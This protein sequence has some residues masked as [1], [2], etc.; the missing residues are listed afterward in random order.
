M[1]AGIVSANVALA[2]RRHLRALHPDRRRGEPRQLGRPAVQPE[3]RGDRHQLADLLAAPA[4][5]RAS[6]FA[7]PIDVA[8]QREGPARRA[9]AR[10]S[11]A[12]SASRIQEVNAVAR[13]VVRPRP[14]ARRAG[15]AGRDG[16]PGRQGRP[17]ARRRDPRGQRQGDRALGRA[18]AAGGGGEAGLEGRRSTCGATAR[19]RTLAVTVGELKRR[20]GRRSAEPS[21]ASDARQARPRACVRC[22]EERSSSTVEQGLVAAGQRPRG[23]RR[24]PARRRHDRGERQAG[25]ER[26]RAAHGRRQG[27]RHASRCS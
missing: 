14:A 19:S 22:A 10:S 5:T 17:Q 15:G 24:H 18:A 12:A 7:I 16:R 21:S 9:P 26:R 2:A 4:A 1:T 13:R 20:A 3:G 23:A 8:M 27:E 6:S 25:E 11:A